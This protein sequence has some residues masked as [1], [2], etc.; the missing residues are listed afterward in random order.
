[1]N[2]TLELIF[3]LLSILGCLILGQVMRENNFRIIQ[4]K[5]FALIAGVA[6]G[7]ATRFFSMPVLVWFPDY[8][9]VLL[10]FFLIEKVYTLPRVTFT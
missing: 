2:A 4:E 9:Q 3:V 5:F 6:I 10:Y 8:C 7:L 1:M